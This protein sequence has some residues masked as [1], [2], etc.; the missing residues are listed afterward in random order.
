[1]PNDGMVCK[2]LVRYIYALQHVLDFF[3]EDVIIMFWKISKTLKNRRGFT[4]VELMIVVVI[5][6]I[7]AGIAVP[8]FTESR[9]LAAEKACQANERIIKGAIAQLIAGGS[10]VNTEEVKKI[11]DGGI[12]KCPVDDSDYTI[13]NDGTLDSHWNEEGNHVTTGD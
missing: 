8:K 2:T 5:I 12:P 1:M 10:D 11:L 4:L 3:Y 9:Q 13:K 6:G 7:L